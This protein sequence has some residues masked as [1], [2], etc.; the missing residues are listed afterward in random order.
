LEILKPQVDDSGYDLVF[1]TRSIVRHVQLKSTKWGSSLRDVNV[2]LQLANKP[3]GC[4]VIIEFDNNLQ[5]GPFYWFG[6]P[7]GERLPDISSFPVARHAKANSQGNKS[8]RPNIKQIPRSS[9][10]K[11]NTIED[12]IEQLFGTSIFERAPGR[13]A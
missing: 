7:P 3:S 6:N 11:L 10:Q 9:F 4:V 5:L 8:Q 12:I 13:S 2:Q 1:E